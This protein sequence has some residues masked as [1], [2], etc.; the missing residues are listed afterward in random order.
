MREA[1]AHLVLVDNPAF[2]AQGDMGLVD[3]RVEPDAA[4]RLT[5]ANVG[6]FA[7]RLF[8]QLPP[9]RARLFPWLYDAARAGRV[10]GERF[11]GRWYNIGT[12]AEL[13]RVDAELTSRG[14]R[15]CS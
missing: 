3:G 11:S 6:V 7:P 8:S 4:E 1:D 14:L 10:S 5:Y 15:H 12:P 13:A 9:D 2:H